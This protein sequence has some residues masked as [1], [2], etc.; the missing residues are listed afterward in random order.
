LPPAT[1]SGGVEKNQKTDPVGKKLQLGEQQNVGTIVG[2]VNDVKIQNLRQRHGWHIY[3]PMAQFPSR[4][5][6]YAVHHSC[7]RAIMGST[8]IALRAGT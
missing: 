5:L 1:G 8:F 2:V 6:A 3:V 4:N 7:L